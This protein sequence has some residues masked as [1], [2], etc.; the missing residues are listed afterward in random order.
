MMKRVAERGEGAHPCG[1]TEERWMIGNVIT[2]VS[3]SIDRARAVSTYNDVHVGRKHVLRSM[4]SKATEV[5][6]ALSARTEDLRR[7][8]FA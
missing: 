1:L 2:Y 5:G 3:S 8:M 4:V 7:F 6:G